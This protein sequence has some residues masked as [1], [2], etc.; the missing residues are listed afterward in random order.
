MYSPDKNL[1][2][3]IEKL[4]L[5]LTNNPIK[6]IA[7]LFADNYP[8]QE[9]IDA[10]HQAGF[11]GVMVDTAFKNGKTLV[12]HWSPKQLDNFVKQVKQHD[13]LCGLAGSLKIEHIANLKKTNTDYLGFRSALC[14]KAERNSTLSVE[15]SRELSQQFNL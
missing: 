15:L 7:V 6:V 14:E 4:A 8:E 11:V 5:T 1:N 2:E 13:L 3:C 12:D 9:I 10:L